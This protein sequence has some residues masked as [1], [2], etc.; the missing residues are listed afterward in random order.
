[1][2]DPQYTR[3]RPCAVDGCPK[4]AYSRY[5]HCAMHRTRLDRYGSLDLPRVAPVTDASGEEWRPCPDY[6]GLYLIS[7]RGRVRRAVAGHGTQAGREMIQRPNSNGYPR[8]DLYR[9][10]RKKSVL[11]HLLVARAFLG[12]CPE[13]HEVNHRD[14]NP[15]NPALT[16]LEYVTHAGNMRHASTHG[17]IARG[18]RSP[19]ARLTAEK[20]RAIRASG[21]SMEKLAARFGVGLT[22]IFN[23]KRRRTWAHVSEENER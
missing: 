4:P 2:A 11:V 5:P 21:E 12:P 1:M 16:N 19:S 9:D 14:T 8:V 18:E 7:D 6:E 13:G 20:V 23:V 22:T 10:G 15:A 17:N 3:V